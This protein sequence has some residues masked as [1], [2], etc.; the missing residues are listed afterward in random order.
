MTLNRTSQVAYS[1]LRYIEDNDVITWHNLADKYLREILVKYRKMETAL[2]SISDDNHT[3]YDETRI[4]LFF[5]PLGETKPIIRTNEI[6]SNCCSAR[7]WPDSDVC[8]NCKEHCSPVKP[9]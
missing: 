7:I 1:M 2:Q 8:S 3:A 5:D 6:V 9:S 4:A